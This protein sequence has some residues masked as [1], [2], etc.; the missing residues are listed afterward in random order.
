MGSRGAISKK[1]TSGG[2]SGKS[3]SASKTTYDYWKGRASYSNAYID[4][5][6]NKNGVTI[7]QPQY[8]GSRYGTPFAVNKGVWYA[9]R[10]IS[11][12]FIYVPEG[13]KRISA[14]GKTIKATDILPQYKVD[15][16]LRWGRYERK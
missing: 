2:G 5:D 10:N 16:I 12:D 8:A 1:T 6:I 7:T 9:A 11:G 15:G 3:A 4:V 14:D 13:D